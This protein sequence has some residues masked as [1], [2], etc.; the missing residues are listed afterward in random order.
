[1]WLLSRSVIALR[2]MPPTLTEDRALARM[3]AQWSSATRLET[4]TKESNIYA[5]VWVSNPCAK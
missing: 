4:R 2:A 1:M 3:L 5:S